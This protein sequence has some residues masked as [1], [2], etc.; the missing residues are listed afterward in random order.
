[1]ANNIFRGKLDGASVSD[2]S[3]QIDY[4]VSDEKGRMEC[5]ENI[6][7]GTDFFEEYFDN[8]FDVHL[9]MEDASLSDN[10]VC[11]LLE[12][13]GT[14]LLNSDEEKERRKKEEEEAKEY[15]LHANPLQFQAEVNKEKNIEEFNVNGS[16][17]GEV[18]IMYFLEKNKKNS[19]KSKHQKITASD[20]KREGEVG[21]VLN[22]YDQFLQAITERIKQIKIDKENGVYNIDRGKR[23]ILTRT[24]NTLKKDMIDAKNILLGVFGYNITSSNEGGFYEFTDEQIESEEVFR[25]L[26]R[27]INQKE[28]ARLDSD[29]FHIFLDLENVINKAKQLNKLTSNELII[30]SGVMEGLRDCDIARENGWS[31]PYVNQQLRRTTKKLIKLL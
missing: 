15:K 11:K 19:R 23:F 21:R 20:L 30:L 2:I 3:K 4:S 1:M 12:E 29:L 13:M 31:N 5:I 26:L 14:Y 27:M 9:N 17:N 6:L 16:S 10:N 25:G 8:Y 7:E 28:K 18:N 24:K 22:E